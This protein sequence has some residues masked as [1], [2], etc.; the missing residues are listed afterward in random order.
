MIKNIKE[1]NVLKTF[2]S[3]NNIAAI[4]HI[5]DIQTYQKNNYRSGLILTVLEKGFDDKTKILVDVRHGLPTINQVYESLY[6]IG[7][8]CDIR[9]ITCTNGANGHDKFNPANF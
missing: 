8:D 2:L 6:K 5:I 3:K 7:K 4:D 1:E 9:I